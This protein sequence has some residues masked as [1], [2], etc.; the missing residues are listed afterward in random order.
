MPD[1]IETGTFLVAAAMAGGRVRATHAQPDTLDAVM[2]KLREAGA[3]VE[4]GRRLDRGRIRRQAESGGRAHRAVSGV[5]HRHAGAVHGAEHHRRRRRQ[6]HRN[7]FRKP[8]HARA[9]TAPPGRQHRSGRPHCA[10]ARRAAAGRR[11][12]HGDRSARFGLPGAG[13]AGR[14]GARPPSSASTTST[15]A[16]SASRKSSPSLARASSGRINTDIDHEL[17]RHHAGPVQGPHF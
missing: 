15:A 11:H 10:G 4:A 13:R 2:S 3:R 1:R 7:H 8:L 5:P 17:F 16:T 14:G 12:R 9:G 6:R